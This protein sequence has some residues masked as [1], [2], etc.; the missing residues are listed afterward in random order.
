MIICAKLKWTYES[1]CVSSL[2]FTIESV[3]PS[4]LTD[5]F[6]MYVN[7]PLIL[8]N[9]SCMYTMKYALSLTMK[10]LRK[11]VSTSAWSET[12]AC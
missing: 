9:V 12:A 8:N 11:K 3:I 10:A 4:V 1:Q 2:F 7:S 5:I 6:F